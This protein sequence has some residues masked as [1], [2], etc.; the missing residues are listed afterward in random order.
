[1]IVNESTSSMQTIRLIDGASAG[2][3]GAPPRAQ[4]KPSV[5]E[6]AGLTPVKRTFLNAVP[7][8]AITEQECIDLILSKI[9]VGE[10]GFCVT[11]NLDH[12]RRLESDPAFASICAE[13]DIRTADGM[14]VVWLSRFLR[15]RVPERVAGSSLLHTLS[16]EASKKG[17]SIYLLGG[18][19]GTAEAA[20]QTLQLRNPGLIVAGTHYVPF[21]FEKNDAVMKEMIRE[22]QRAAPDIVY[23]ALGSPKQEILIARI[24]KYLPHAWWMG[25]GISFSYVCGRVKQAPAWMRNIGCEWI[26]RMIQEPRRLVGRYLGEGV[27]FALWLLGRCLKDYFR[28]GR[29]RSNGQDM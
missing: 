19:E 13:A 9:E 10:G 2:Q 17:V 21:G 8:D 14:P 4:P 22:L 28:D 26:Y 12:I 18:D 7:I 6:P 1:M 3:T 11:H 20:A 5:T 23:V 16:A 24:R 25:V 15:M 27:P 29:H